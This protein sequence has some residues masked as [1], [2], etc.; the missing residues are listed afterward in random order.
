MKAFVNYEQ[1]PRHQVKHWKVQLVAPP[2]GA[3]AAWSGRVGHALIYTER[4]VG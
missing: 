3:E 1:G 2:Y 4:G